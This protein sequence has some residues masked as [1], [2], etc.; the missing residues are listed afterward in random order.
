MDRMRRMTWVAAFLI[1]LAG[2][3][4]PP[5]AHAGATAGADSAR[6][7]LYGSAP[8]S[9]GT[10]LDGTVEWALV[11]DGADGPRIE[12]VVTL[13]GER[14]VEIALYRNTDASLPAS[15]LVELAFSA[16][17]APEVASVSGIV[18]KASDSARGDPLAAVSV[19]VADGFFMIALAGGAADAA[20]NLRLLGTREWIDIPLV[21]ATGGRAVLAVE[22]GT[23]GRE[24]FD[25]AVAAWT[26]SGDAAGPD[27][28]RP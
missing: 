5:G 11:E 22:K 2:W 28:A 10:A 17:T 12:A 9:P 6:A 1:A 21:Y 7:V 8:G 16:S 20:L 3:L 14:R 25:R 15:H 19:K 18:M 26:S 13:P 4:A 27:A 23:A 24:A